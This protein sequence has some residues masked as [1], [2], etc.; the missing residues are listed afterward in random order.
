MERDAGQ[1]SRSGGISNLWRV[2]EIPLAVLSFAVHF[3]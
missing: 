3:V 2:P 1:Q